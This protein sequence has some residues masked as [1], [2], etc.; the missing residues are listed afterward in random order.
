MVG[1]TLGETPRRSRI[2]SAKRR[3][4]VS[5]AVVVDAVQHPSH[6]GTAT[7]TPLALSKVIAAT[8]RRRVP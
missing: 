1:V 4:A 7:G 2:C 6:R 5:R 3:L 8:P